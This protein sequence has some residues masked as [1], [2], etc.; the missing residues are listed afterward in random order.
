MSQKKTNS[1]VSEQLEI[2]ERIRE[3]TEAEM[4]SIKD[5]NFSVKIKNQDQ[6]IEA[7][8]YVLNKDVYEIFKVLSHIIMV[9]KLGVCVRAVDIYIKK[10]KCVFL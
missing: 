8:K 2:S 7:K 1:L 6:F 5:S 10:H 9:F 3:K 4:E